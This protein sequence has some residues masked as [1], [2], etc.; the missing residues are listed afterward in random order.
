MNMASR[1]FFFNF[2]FELH[3]LPGVLSSVLRIVVISLGFQWQFEKICTRR[4]CCRAEG[5]QEGH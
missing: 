3:T 1:T 4:E 2:V 5:W